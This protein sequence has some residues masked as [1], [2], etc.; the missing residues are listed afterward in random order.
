M[1]ITSDFS[2]KNLS[3]I[4]MNVFQIGIKRGNLKNCDENQQKN[5][6]SEHIGSQIVFI[7]VKM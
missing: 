1:I 4:P 3:Y 7:R 2:T 5:I 6:K